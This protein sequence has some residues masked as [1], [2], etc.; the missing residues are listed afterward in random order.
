MLGWDRPDRRCGDLELYEIADGKAI[1][2]PDDPTVVIC[3]DEFGPLNLQP[4]PGKQWAPIAAGKGDTESPRR[5][6]MR[7]TCTRPNGVRHLMAGY[8]LSTNRLYGHVVK[9]KGRT[10][11]CPQVLVGTFVP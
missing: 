5:R 8:D 11:F 7:A 4:H 6:R 2:G 9:K 10:A 1:P 3:M